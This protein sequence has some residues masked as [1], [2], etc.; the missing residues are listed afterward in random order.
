MQDINR[1]LQ[2]TIVLITHE[3]DVLRHIC[4]SAAVIEGGQI[5]E[6]GPVEQL[7]YRPESETAKQFVNIFNYYKDA[8]AEEKAVVMR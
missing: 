7:F 6:N 8:N 2:L 3:M 4:M 1:K 5:V